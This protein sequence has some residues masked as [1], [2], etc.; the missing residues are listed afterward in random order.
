MIQGTPEHTVQQNLNN[1]TMRICRRICYSTH[2]NT[3]FYD[4]IILRFS[5]FTDWH[6]H[7]S[8]LALQSTYFIFSFAGTSGSCTVIIPSRLVFPMKAGLVRRTSGAV[9]AVTLCCSPPALFP[10]FVSTNEYDF[11]G[12]RLTINFCVARPS[13]SSTIFPSS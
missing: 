5:A 8:T 13:T 3:F 4:T 10:R 2:S 9:F 11:S 7:P 12:F 6:F 1:N